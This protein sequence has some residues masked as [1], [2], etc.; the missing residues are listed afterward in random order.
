MKTVLEYFDIYPK[1]LCTEREVTVTIQP[2]GEHVAFDRGADYQVKLVPMNATLINLPE[3]EYER[4]SV[5]Q[6]EGKRV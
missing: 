1:V 5:K 3:R 2:M 6:E 4:I